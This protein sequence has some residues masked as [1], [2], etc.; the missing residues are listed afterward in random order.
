MSV[1]LVVLV[2]IANHSR[3][4]PLQVV[5]GSPLVRLLLFPALLSY[6]HSFA[7]HLGSSLLA[8]TKDLD[9]LSMLRSSGRYSAVQQ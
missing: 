7:I 1:R 9:L 8:L 3:Y 5:L 2:R 6:L 4:K